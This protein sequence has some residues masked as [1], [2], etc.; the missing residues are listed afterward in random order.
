MNLQISSK[1]KISSIKYSFYKNLLP[2]LKKELN[3]DYL[4][5]P[6]PPNILISDKNYPSIKG[7]PIFSLSNPKFSSNPSLLYGKSY[8]FIL[9][10][11]ASN[12]L[13]FNKINIKNNQ[14]YEDLILSYKPIDT[15]VNFF[16]KPKISFIS[17]DFVP[18]GSLVKISSLKIAENP[19]IP[20]ITYKAIEGDL[21]AEESIMLLYNKTNIH[22]TIR[23]LSGG[24]L[25]IKKKMVPT[26]WAITAVDDIIAKNLINRIKEYNIINSYYVF[27]NSFLENRFTIILLPKP[28]EYEQFEFWFNGK[29]GYNREYEPYSGRKKYAEK[30]AGGYY[31]ARLGVLEYL[32]K[33]KK[34]A[35]VL[36]IREIFDYPIPVGVWQV[37]ESV[38]NAFKK[39][40]K[41]DTIKEVFNYLDKNIKIKKW[42]ESFVLK[43]RNLFDF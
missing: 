39:P 25:G 11:F 36:V 32:N 6:S 15:E 28:W 30:Q 40:L 31:A 18:S 37:R 8:Q 12:I 3:K 16:N 34:Q 43:Q 14:K 42:K 23:L 2:K 35:S 7:G 26:K 9:E 29:W 21:K 4:F 41:F 20:K 38:R 17:S 5:A 10:Q 24:F 1:E 19:K 22:Y 33:I 27:T 13:G